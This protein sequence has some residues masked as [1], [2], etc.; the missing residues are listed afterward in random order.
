KKIFSALANELI[1]ELNPGRY[2]Q[3][4]M[5]FGATVCTPSAPGCNECPLKKSC[6]SFRK[7]IVQVLPVRTKKIKSRDRFFN[8]FIIHDDNHLLLNKRNGND[9]WEGLYEFP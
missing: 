2:N 4:I 1:D 5:D 7:K 3:A 9:I 8:Y 6:Y